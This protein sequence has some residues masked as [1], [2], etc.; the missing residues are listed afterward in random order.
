MRGTTS[1]ARILA[2]AAFVAMHAPGVEARTLREAF[3]IAYE[4]NPDLIAARADLRALDESVN[5]ARAGMR[6][7]V[8]LEFRYEL[9]ARD[10]QIAGRQDS[11]PFTARVV[12][13]QAIYDGGR[14]YNSVLGRVADVS[15]ARSRLLQ[16]EQQV[17]LDV[18]TA[19]VDILRDRAFVDLAQNNV[20]VISEQ[21]RA[22][23]D[24]FEVGEVTRTDVS[25]A[26]ARLAESRARLATSEAQLARSEQTFRAVVG[27]EPFGLERTPPLP[28]LPASL[29]A[30]VD[31]AL[32]NHPLLSAARFDETSARRDVRTAVGGLLPT[33]SLEASGG[34]DD[35]SVLLDDLRN[36]D[37]V[38]G[39]VG[40][41]ARIPI[42]QGGA[43]YSRVRQAQ[44][45]A[46]S[47]RAGLSVEAR[48]RRRQAEAAWTE[49]LAAR[50]NIVAGRE[51]V[52]A[53]QLA[54]EGVREEAIVGSRTT[55][56]VLDA[57][58]ELLDARSRLVETTRNE[59]VAAYS[60]L[61]TIGALTMADLDVAAVAYDPAINYDANNARFFGFE[62]DEDTVWETLWRP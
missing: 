52:Q 32:Q 36:N 53:A 30:A 13:S 11:D 57:E 48:E 12:A 43:A 4:T 22:S 39:A 27:E 7:D 50:A 54:F 35:N 23:Q 17:L 60:L 8:D 33:V 10:S 47:A 42:Y 58:Q 5:Q 9:E 40:V 28:T 20:R 16:L 61:S 1:M 31:L 15:A 41:V 14:T 3:A 59:F 34:Y 46:S 18:A 19:Y 51:Q 29:D 24:R 62:R 2:L 21:L 38:S 44:A 56:D 6:P 45:R 37:T 25:Q 49:L 55:L 26:E